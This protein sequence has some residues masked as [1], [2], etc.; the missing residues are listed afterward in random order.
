M[1]AKH[2]PGRAKT[3]T[4][5]YSSWFKIREEVDRKAT[6]AFWTSCTFDEQRNVMRYHTGTL[7]NQKHA[8]RYKLSNNISCPLC[9]HVDSALHMLSGC[10]HTMI[11]NMITERHNKACRIILQALAK[12][13]YGTNLF[14][15]DAG[16]AARFADQGIDTTNV[17]NRALPSWLLNHIS[18]HDRQLSSRPDAIFILPSTTCSTQFTSANSAI[19]HFSSNEFDPSHWEVHLIEFKYCEDTRPHLQLERAQ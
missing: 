13:N 3:D 4:I 9:T 7:F 17:A 14:Y 6:N 8:V 19:N 15:T 11:R 5:Y 18:D 1:Q 16:S 10:Q 12:G 2:R